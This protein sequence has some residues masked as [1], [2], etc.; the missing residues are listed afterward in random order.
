MKFQPVSVQQL[1]KTV[2]CYILVKGPVR[3]ILAGEGGVGKTTLV[4]AY[5]NK[6]ENSSTHMTIGVNVEGFLVKTPNIPPVIV[7]DLGGQKQFMEIRDMMMK[8]ANVVI[9]VFDRTYPRSFAML[10]WWMEHIINN[11]GPVP[12]IL[13]ENKIDM[14]SR[15]MENQ[16]SELIERYPQIVGFVR[17]SATAGINVKELFTAAIMVAM[18][19][20]YAPQELI[21]PV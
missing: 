3:I 2:V 1:L 7:I 10:D 13:V 6:L 19:K 4:K 20:E 16:I 12:V 14:P 18:G 15:I 9:L 21:E 17:T 8:Y 11:L 5:L